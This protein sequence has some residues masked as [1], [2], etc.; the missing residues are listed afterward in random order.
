MRAD[1]GEP[2]EGNGCLEDCLWVL[3]KE[4]SFSCS[5]WP[6]CRV[7]REKENVHENVCYQ[8]AKMA[9]TIDVFQDDIA[10]L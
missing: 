6:I 10:C 4:A 1:G 2:W 5:A 8:F 3:L 7:E 9:L